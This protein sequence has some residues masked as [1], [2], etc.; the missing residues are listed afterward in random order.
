MPVFLYVGRI[1]VEK[2]IEAFLRLDL[3]GTKLLIGGGPSL[4]KLRAAYPEA[5]FLGPKVGLEL[6]RYYASADVFVFP[7]RTDTFGLVLLEALASG[8]PVAAYP[9]SGPIDVIG[10]APVGVLDDDLRSAALR[11]L[12]VPREGCRDYS[13]NFT[14]ARSTD[15]FLAHLPLIR[16]GVPA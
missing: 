2:N 3:P 8:T 5:V 12:E 6:A 9:V 7:S 10:S 4:D 13:M 11:A 14:W 16:T 1:A 15:A